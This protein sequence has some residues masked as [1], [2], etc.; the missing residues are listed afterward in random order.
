MSPVSLTIVE[1]PGTIA[2]S[3]RSAIID[4]VSV[5]WRVYIIENGVSVMNTVW[6]PW[7]IYVRC[8]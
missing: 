3:G 2:W 6:I 4:P 5:V 7:V 1:E 8:L